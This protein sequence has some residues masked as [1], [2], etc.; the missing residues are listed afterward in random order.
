M[1]DLLK[2]ARYS[3]GIANAWDE[4]DQIQRLLHRTF[5]LEIGQD[6]DSGTGCLLDKFHDKNTYIVAAH[7]N[8]VCGVVAL[9]DQ[10]PFSAISDLE[11]KEQLER[12]VPEI[13]EA[14]RFAITRSHRSGIIFAGITW[15]IY[16]HAMEQGYRYILISGLLQRRRMYERMGFRAFGRIVRKGAADF[17]PML[18]DLSALPEQIRMDLDRWRRRVLPFSAEGLAAMSADSGSLTMELAKSLVENIDFGDAER[19]WQK[20]SM[21]QPATGNVIAA[22]YDDLL[23]WAPRPL[24][25]GRGAA[26]RAAKAAIARQFDLFT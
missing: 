23:L 18:L 12:L 2:I 7:G 14:R 11:C 6:E 9:H 1:K 19:V 13:V 25:S 22:D 3:F 24:R 21:V 5:V 20:L 8:H 16:Q 15:V 4:Q 10:T 17:I 26:A